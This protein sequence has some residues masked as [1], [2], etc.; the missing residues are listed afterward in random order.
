M[1][2]KKKKIVTEQAQ[3][4]RPNFNPKQIPNKPN[5][6]VFSKKKKKKKKPKWQNPIQNSEN[7]NM[8]PPQS[9]NGKIKT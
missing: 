8:H 1:K 9:S 3:K 7:T 6:N 4:K 5:P 2:K